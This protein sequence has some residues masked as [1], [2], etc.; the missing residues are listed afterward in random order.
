MLWDHRAVGLFAALRALG[1]A[2]RAMSL[3]ERRRFRAAMR[4]A[5]REQTKQELLTKG[6][7]LAS[8]VGGAIVTLVIWGNDHSRG[9]RVLWEVLTIAAVAL[10]T[11]VSWERWIGHRRRRRRRT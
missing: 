8:L 9:W 2:E 5:Q 11:W 4:A 6:R 10:P 7:M 1:D 3:D